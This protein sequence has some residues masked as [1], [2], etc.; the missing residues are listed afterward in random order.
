MPQLPAGSQ[1]HLPDGPFSQSRRSL[2][3]LC[4]SGGGYRGLFSARVLAQIEKR[5]L[6]GESIAS[7]FELLAGTSVGGLIACGLAVGKSAQHL[8][9]TLVDRS[10]QIFPRLRW[11]RL[12]KALPPPY[13]PA[14]LEPLAETIRD[15]G[16][17]GSK[18]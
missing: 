4:L 13:D 10:P 14:V 6:G 17:L 1:H 12:R 11:R 8:Q 5:L 15:S 7:R 9:D 16:L 3:V 18:Y 2:R